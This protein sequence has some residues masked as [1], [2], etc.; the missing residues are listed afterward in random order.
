MDTRQQILEKNFH[1]I[2]LNGYQGTRTD[3]V[4][5]GLGITKGAF[6]HYFASKQA[7][8]YA[9]VDEIIAPM[10]VNTWKVLE[11][12]E[13][14]PIEQ[15]N[16]V[17]RGMINNT[18][19][20]QVVLGCPLNNLM[21]EMSPLDDGFRIRFQEI[22]NQLR[23]FIED[24]LRRGQD[25]NTVTNTIDPTQVAL[26]VLAGLEGSYSIAKSLQSKDAFKSSV[27]QIIMFLNILKV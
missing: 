23:I 17:L 6:Y 27:N 19:A 24:A 4:I 10:F 20:E 8:G 9:V 5:E 11:S 3:K 25:N 12:T 21:Q 16:K 15:I 2:W 7:L 18:P 13:G 22:I 1:S 14:N 26:F